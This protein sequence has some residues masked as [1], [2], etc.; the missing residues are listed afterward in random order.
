M[1]F[2]TETKIGGKIKFSQSG[3]NDN[4]KKQ[5]IEMEKQ[6]M[7]GKNDEKEYRYE[8]QGNYITKMR[9]CILGGLLMVTLVE[10]IV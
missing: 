10:C 6:V 5:K 9:S 2:H 7:K 3:F 4:H 1:G 8:S